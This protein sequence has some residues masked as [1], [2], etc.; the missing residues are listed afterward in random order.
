MAL[1]LLSLRVRLQRQAAEQF[2][3]SCSA[4]FIDGSAAGPIGSDETCE[5]VQLA[6]LEAM[7]LTLTPRAA[8]PSRAKR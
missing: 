2:E 8:R 3:L 6:P 7:Q 5:S 4:T 1:P